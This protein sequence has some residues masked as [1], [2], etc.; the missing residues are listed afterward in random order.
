[1]TKL[2][3]NLRDILISE[4]LDLMDPLEHSFDL[5]EL[6]AQ[7]GL[8]AHLWSIEDVQEVRPDLSDEQAWE[9]LQLCDRRKDS[10]LGITWETLDI[11]A[12]EL[13]PA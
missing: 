5:K 9:V 13:Y 12:E 7:H 8:I 11:L 3:L 2:H 4:L 1:M 10:N 6:L